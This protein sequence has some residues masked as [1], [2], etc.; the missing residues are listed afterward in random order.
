MR[1]ILLLL[2]VVLG[3]ISVE[4]EFRDIQERDILTGPITESIP[5]YSLCAITLYYLIRSITN[6]QK[7]KKL[8]AFI[9]SVI[10]LVLIGITS[11]HKIIRS[12]Q[13]NYQTLFI[14]SSNEFGNDGGFRL[15]FKENKVLIG[16][17]IDRF[18]K[19]TYWGTYKQEEDTIRIDIPLNFQL[20]KTA[21]LQD[22]VLYFPEDSL[23]FEV[24]Q[25]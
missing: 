12:N 5:F 4:F 23:R 24:F 25:H 10:G 3:A 7:H 19:T 8:V 11:N 22:S 17:K 2:L 16:E 14:A 13:K 9:P 18:N 6:Y 15:N 20:G 21:L 1:I